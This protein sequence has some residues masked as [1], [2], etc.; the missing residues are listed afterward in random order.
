MSTRTDCRATCG[1][2][3]AVLPTDLF[4]DVLDRFA[5]FATSL[6]K[7]FLH[8]SCGSISFAFFAQLLVVIHLADLFLELALGLVDLPLHFVFVPHEVLP[9]LH[10]ES[11]AEL[12]PLC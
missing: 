11:S 2:D 7:R 3:D 9:F 4:S 6:A 10:R 1:K 12:V 5:D 8:V